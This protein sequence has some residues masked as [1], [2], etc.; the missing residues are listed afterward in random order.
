MAVGSSTTFSSNQVA[1]GN[2]FDGGE[3]ITV[4]VWIN[5]TTRPSNANIFTDTPSGL[6]FQFLGNNGPLRVYW[7]TNGGEAV[8]TGA[9]SPSTST[10]TYV[11]LRMDFGTSVCDIDLNNVNDG[12]ST[13][14]GTALTNPTSTVTIGSQGGS[15]YFDGKM[16]H[17]QVW[18]DAKYRDVMS[19]AMYMP[20]TLPVNLTAHIPMYIAETTMT[21]KSGEG[22]TGTL[23]GTQTT[24]DSG[25]PVFTLGGQ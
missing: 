3:A 16:S 24:S 10:W 19:Q 13:P 7:E 21:D 8:T 1:L 20:G 25:P 17:F 14:P 9:T 22:N 4:G 23:A 15:E 11:V 6:W 2:I 18:L 5:P 12:T